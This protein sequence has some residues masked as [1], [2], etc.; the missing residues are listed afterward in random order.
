LRGK[1]KLVEHWEDYERSSASFYVKN[2]FEGF[3]PV[4]YEELS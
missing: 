2:K 3:V 1:S 4:H